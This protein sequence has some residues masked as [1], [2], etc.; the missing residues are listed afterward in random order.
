[1]GILVL[2]IIGSVI[3]AGAVFIALRSIKLDDD[4]DTGGQHTA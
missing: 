4:K 1:M 2:S 3:T